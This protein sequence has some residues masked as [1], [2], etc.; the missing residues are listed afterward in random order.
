MKFFPRHPALPGTGTLSEIRVGQCLTGQT[1]RLLGDTQF[2][3]VEGDRRSGKSTTLGTLYRETRRTHGAGAFFVVDTDGALAR[4]VRSACPAT[5]LV[6]ISAR[7]ILS[8]ILTWAAPDDVSAALAAACARPGQSRWAT[9][10]QW[11]WLYRRLWLSGQIPSLARLATE[12]RIEASRSAE[13]V[14]LWADQWDDDALSD[15]LDMGLDIRKTLSEKMSMRHAE[16]ASALAYLAD[17]LC[18]L[19]DR[20]PTLDEKTPC[21]RC[22]RVLSDLL[23]ALQAGC[24]LVLDLSELSAAAQSLVTVVALRALCGALKRERSIVLRGVLL[25]NAAPAVRRE[26]AAIRRLNLRKFTVGV[27]HS[28]SETTD[29]DHVFRTRVIH[30]SVPRHPPVALLGSDCLEKLCEMEAG[31][32]YLLDWNQVAA[33]RIRVG[34]FS[35]ESRYLTVAGVYLPVEC[36]ASP[37]GATVR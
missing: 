24:T 20:I 2:V 28:G 4:Q 15:L 18:A 1:L 31:D 34:E 22:D 32:A 25:D 13:K 3:S 16:R 17:R 36:P 26:I 23:P 21:E 30:R 19:P 14:S 5:E 6:T 8:S 37:G 10:A 27:S 29:S 11:M 33:R 7:R 9:R 35:T 12:T